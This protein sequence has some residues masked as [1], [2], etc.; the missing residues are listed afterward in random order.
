MKAGDAQ[1]VFLPLLT[2]SIGTARA[3]IYP[4][5]F[6]SYIS[7]YNIAR[8]ND[9]NSIFSLQITDVAYHFSETKVLIK[10]SCNPS[11]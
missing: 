11:C 7:C 1:N 3:N 9:L 6:L 8:I 2:L 10:A 5:P 4:K